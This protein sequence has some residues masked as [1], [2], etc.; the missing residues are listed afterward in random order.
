MI[1]G[2]F[3]LGFLEFDTYGDHSVFPSHWVGP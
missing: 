1:P 2:L 3:K